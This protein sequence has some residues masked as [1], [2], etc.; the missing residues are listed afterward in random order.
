MGRALKAQVGAFAVMRGKRVSGRWS[1]AI[2]AKAKGKAVAK[3]RAPGSAGG[4]ARRS[5]DGQRDLF[6]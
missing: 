3:G 1:G 4:R 6:R 5:A 2:D